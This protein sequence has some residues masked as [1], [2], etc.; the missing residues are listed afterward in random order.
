M[1]SFFRSKRAH[2]VRFPTHRHLT[3][4]S[5]WQRDDSDDVLHPRICAR[6]HS[7]RQQFSGWGRWL[8]ERIDDANTF[9]VLE[10]WQVLRVQSLNT[11]G[12]GV[13]ST[14][15]AIFCPSSYSR[16]IF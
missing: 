2:W 5:P 11:S 1:P 7:R 16:A 13:A 6:P 4:V 9:E 3:G 8:L 12:P 14:S 10:S 15:S